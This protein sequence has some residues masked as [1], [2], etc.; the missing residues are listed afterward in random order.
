MN[1]T[2]SCRTPW[3]V[4]ENCTTIG[5]WDELGGMVRIALRKL[6]VDVADNPSNSSTAG[7]APRLRIRRVRFSVSPTAS[8]PKSSTVVSHAST[9]ST[10][11]VRSSANMGGD[12]IVPAPS[13]DGSSSRTKHGTRHLAW[14]DHGSLASF[15]GATIRPPGDCTSWSP[16]RLPPSPPPTAVEYDTVPTCSGKSSRD[17]VSAASASAFAAASA[18]AAAAA[19]ASAA[20]AAFAASSSALEGFFALPLPFPLPF[21]FFASSSSAAF[22]SSAA[23][24]A[25][26]A[27]AAEAPPIDS[28]SPTMLGSV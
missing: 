22:A 23:L 18:A 4:G 16:P 14:R 25:A 20:A 15:S 9:R 24:A 7:D 28:S 13:T 3:P 27:S 8:S 19:S 2:V 26:S 12:T 6:K 21:P 5:G 1:V 10:V 17:G 11:T